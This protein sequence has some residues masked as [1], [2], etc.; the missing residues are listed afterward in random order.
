MIKVLDPDNCNIAYLY[1]EHSQECSCVTCTTLQKMQIFPHGK[2]FCVRFN[3]EQLLSN[4][5]LNPFFN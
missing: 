5:R 1:E 4:H 3:L 2:E